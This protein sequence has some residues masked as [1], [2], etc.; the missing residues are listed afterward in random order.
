M[1]LEFSYKLGDTRLN[2]IVAQ[3]H[4]EVAVAQEVTSGRNGVGESERR[5][6]RDVGDINPPSRTV[7]HR[8]F[9]RRSRVAG[10]YSEILNSGFGDGLD[11]VFDHWLV[12]DWNELLCH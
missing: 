5:R 2:E 11:P 10:D 4:D 12:C 9:D 6:L 3:I 7:T 1:S 8:S